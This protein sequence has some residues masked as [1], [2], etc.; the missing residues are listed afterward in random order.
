M[1]EFSTF[2][3]P[4]PGRVWGWASIFNI[5]LSI[6]NIQH[7]TFNIRLQNYI[8][9][10]KNTNDIEHFVLPCHFFEDDILQA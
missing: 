1:I 9:N 7:S 5:Q 8:K 2:N 3:L 4:S 6:F 10:I